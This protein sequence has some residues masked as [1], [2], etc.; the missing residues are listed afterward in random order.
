[1]ETVEHVAEGPQAL[2]A[3][4]SRAWRLLA[5]LFDYPDADLAA[6]A[7]E[8]EVAA[9]LREVVAGLDPELALA[10]DADAL[11]DAGHDEDDLAVE[12]TRLFDVGAAGPPCPL[13]GG[14]YAGDRMKVMEEAVRF[15]NHFGL[16][17]AE[18]PRELPDHLVTELEFLH[19]LAF[20]EAQ[21]LGAG[22]DPGAW[23]RAQRDFLTRHPGRFVPKLRERMAGLDPIGFYAALVG[24]LE[25]LLARETSRL[26]ESEGAAPAA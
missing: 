4:R 13:Y 12:Y 1:M 5:S 19:F 16:R 8:G 6:A 2:A 23:R 7:R 14:L 10:V 21:A 9:V 22:E 17:P 26:V 20:R 18:S 25:A 15:Y 11:A 24:L 3:T